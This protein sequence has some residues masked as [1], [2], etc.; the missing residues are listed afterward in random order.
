ML[1]RGVMKMTQ[2]VST[3]ELLEWLA[4]RLDLYGYRAMPCATCQR[5]GDISIAV[6]HGLV[7]RAVNELRRSAAETSGM[8]ADDCVPTTLL[9]EWATE[10]IAEE[11]SHVFRD[12]QALARELL[13]RRR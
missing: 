11:R 8:A 4:D 3:S 5:D 12:R 1:Y 10:E 6:M 9:E 7:R 2:H 13:E